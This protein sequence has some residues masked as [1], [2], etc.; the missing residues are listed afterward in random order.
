MCLRPHHSSNPPLSLGRHTHSLTQACG[1]Q[2]SFTTPIFLSFILHP[3]PSLTW[4][5]TGACHPSFLRIPVKTTHPSPPCPYHPYPSFTLPITTFYP[6]P[7]AHRSRNPP[8]AITPR[9]PSL[10]EFPRRHYIRTSLASGILPSPLHPDVPRIRNSSRRH[11]IRTSLASGILPSTF[12]LLRVSHIRNPILQILLN[13]GVQIVLIAPYFILR[14][15]LSSKIT[16][17]TKL[18]CHFHFWQAIFILPLFF[19]M[20]WNKQGIKFCN[21]E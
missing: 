4:S 6:H 21:P 8:A 2:A 7:D 3:T 20:F 15:S 11:S 13:P 18:C 10:P 14:V 16:F 12:H 17:L 1:N 5:L 9:R 19:K